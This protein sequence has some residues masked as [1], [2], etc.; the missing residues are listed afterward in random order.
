MGESRM[1]AIWVKEQMEEASKFR[2]KEGKI[3]G[4]IY[5]K[6]Q[7]ETK[8]EQK[9]QIKIEKPDYD[10]VEL[11]KILDNNEMEQTPK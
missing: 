10:E 11:L 8:K 2:D 6:V 7:K 1:L 4:S 3:L 9:K 5:E